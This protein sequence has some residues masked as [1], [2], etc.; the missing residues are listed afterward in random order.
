MKINKTDIPYLYYCGLCSLYFHCIQ[1]S[2][3]CP[4][5]LTKNLYIKI[6]ASHDTNTGLL[7]G[8]K[9]SCIVERDNCNIFYAKTD[10]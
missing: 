9:I 5:C 1:E 3:S 2:K 4:L 7:L 6:Y 10:D 8:N